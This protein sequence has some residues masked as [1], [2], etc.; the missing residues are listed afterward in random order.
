[1]EAANSD[2]TGDLSEE[3][4]KPGNADFIQA[5]VNNAEYSLAKE[6]H[7]GL[8][9][10]DDDESVESDARQSDDDQ[11]EFEIDGTTPEEEEPTNNGSAM[12]SASTGGVRGARLE[13]PKE[14]ISH[15]VF[16][17]T[18]CSWRILGR[19][20]Y[21]VPGRREK[22]NGPLPKSSRLSAVYRQ[23]P[24]PSPF[25]TY[26]VMPLT[27]RS[28]A[29]AMGILTKRGN[30]VQGAGCDNQ[31]N[32]DLFFMSILNRLTGRPGVFNAY[33]RKSESTDKPILPHRHH[34]T[35]F[36]DFVRANKAHKRLFSSQHYGALPLDVKESADVF[37]DCI[38]SFADTCQECLEDMGPWQQRERACCLDILAGYLAKVVHE[39]KIHMR[40]R[41]W[42]VSKSRFLAHQIMADLEEVYSC[43][44]GMVTLASI[45]SSS[46]G[47]Q[48]M[49]VCQLSMKQSLSEVT[50]QP[51]TIKVVLHNV[52]N[53]L[54]GSSAKCECYR[55]ALGCT[56]NEDG[57]VVVALNE[58]PLNEIDV[59]HFMCKLY[60]G[61]SKTMPGR[62]N[63]EYPLQSKQGMHP[64]FNPDTDT[65]LPWEDD[66][67]RQILEGVVSAHETIIRNGWITTTP[68]IFLLLQEE[69]PLLTKGQSGVD[70]AN[71]VE[72]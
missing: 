23:H 14:L 65:A 45:V 37:F 19:S 47:L 49:R 72:V 60:T 40:E 7:Q 68:E 15:L 42:N 62:S 44:F 46:G 51:D 25:R 61:I 6:I 9:N 55:R 58:R 21:V 48:G 67:L 34:V 8:A 63:T 66:F 41:C 53:L 69:D 35:G 26:D 33:R 28:C 31:I 39:N 18:A 43:P 2:A 11:S 29:M 38:R 56:L 1:M 36:V 32:P 50:P 17:M 20:L 4:L 30:R 22:Q 59:E 13:N 5:Y 54:N 3:W 16:M 57:K 64:I 10:N 70:V 27:I 12:L 24:M 52:L 71:V